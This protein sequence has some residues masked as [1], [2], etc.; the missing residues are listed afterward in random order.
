MTKR[1]QIL[2]FNIANQQGIAGMW[3]MDGYYGAQAKSSP[4][5]TSCSWGTPLIGQITWKSGDPSALLPDNFM[6]SWVFPMIWR[7][8]N[9]QHGIDAYQRIS[10]NRHISSIHTWLQLRILG[11]IGK[12]HL[13]CRGLAQRPT[14]SPLV[15]SPALK[16]G[17]W[18]IRIA[19][20]LPWRFESRCCSIDP[21]INRLQTIWSL[22][23]IQSA[24]CFLSVWT[25]LLMFACTV[26][27][28]TD[29]EPQAF[30]PYCTSENKKWSPHQFSNLSDLAWRL[31]CRLIY[32]S[33]SEE[34]YI[35]MIQTVH[36][37]CSKCRR[38]HGTT[39][40]KP[41][42]VRFIGQDLFSRLPF[43]KHINITSF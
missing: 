40:S 9:H 41:C 34:L 24:V 30:N 18:L 5:A 42:L 43:R 2:G 31:V 13:S 11:T 17:S 7:M 23:A 4:E 22:N 26:S 27:N 19:S 3:D 25:L 8:R 28:V 14:V 16:A 35:I 12:D 38:L 1:C 6:I 29:L 15:T 37:Q 10:D 36:K 21:K 32:T 33:Q 39:N 20:A